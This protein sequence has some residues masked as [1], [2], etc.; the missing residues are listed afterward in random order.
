MYN[1]ETFLTDELLHLTHHYIHTHAAQTSILITHTNEMN[2][3]KRES[4]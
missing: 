4:N 3:T 2:F 1:S